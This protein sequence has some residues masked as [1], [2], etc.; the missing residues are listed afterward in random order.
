MR[1][2]ITIVNV[3]V[4][5]TD[6]VVVGTGGV[7]YACANT[8]NLLTVSHRDEEDLRGDCCLNGSSSLTHSD[9]SESSEVLQASICQVIQLHALSRMPWPEVPSLGDCNHS[10]HMFH[11][12]LAKQLSSP[13]SS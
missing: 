6:I 12:R 4:A 2:I 8:C 13:T 9:T 1:V 5:I 3:V 7:V 10:Q 11:L